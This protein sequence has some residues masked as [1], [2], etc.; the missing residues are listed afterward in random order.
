MKVTAAEV[1][2]HRKRL[3]SIMTFIGHLFNQNM[4]ASNMIHWYCVLLFEPR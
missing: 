1:A 4:L 2:E 3:L